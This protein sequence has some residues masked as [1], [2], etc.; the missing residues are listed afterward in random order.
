MLVTRNVY[1]PIA[2]SIRHHSAATQIGRCRRLPKILLTVYPFATQLLGGFY[3]L[4]RGMI[5][6]VCLSRCV[7]GAGAFVYVREPHAAHHTA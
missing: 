4:P 1:V 3:V 6:S 7:Y 5:H 2:F